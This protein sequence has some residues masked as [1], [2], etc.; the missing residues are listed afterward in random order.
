MSEKDSYAPGAPNWIDIGTPDP[1]T[2]AKFYSELF[3]WQIEGGDP[4]YGGYR[5]A[6]VRGRTVAGIGHAQDPSTPPWWTTYIC[7]TDAEETAKRVRDA[8]GQVLSEPFDIGTFGKMAVFTDTGG[9][10][11][12][13]WQANEMIGSGLISEHGTLTWNELHTRDPQRAKDFYGKVFG[14]HFQEMD[15]GVGY[16]YTV[17]KLTEREDDT[18]VVGFMPMTDEPGGRPEHWKVYFAVDDADALSAKATELGGQVLM[19]PQDIPGVGRYGQVSG[20]HGEEINFI[21]NA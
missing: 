12:S 20:P 3:G 2:S 16:I 5:T 15:M 17:G 18:G 19:E 1:E 14:W 11:F 6:V 4:Q 7:V 21:T 9:A 10:P 13:V 8:G